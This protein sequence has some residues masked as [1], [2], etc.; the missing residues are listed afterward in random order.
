MEKSHGRSSLLFPGICLFLFLFLGTTFAAPD[1]P[2]N[3]LLI[4]ADDL[5]YGDVG[6]HGGRIPTPHIDSLARNGMAF[7]QG[8]VTAPQCAPSRAG[9]LTG[10]Y[11][12][13]FGFESNFEKPGR[14]GEPFPGAGLPMEERTMADYLRAAGYH[15]GVIGKWHL[16]GEPQFHP[17]Q[18]GFDEFFGF[19][20]GLSHYL[21]PT[22][23]AI[24]GEWDWD[25][26]AEVSASSMGSA[27]RPIPRMIRNNN[28][29]KVT[30]YLTDVLGEEASAFIERNKDKPWFL[31]LAFNAPHVPLEAS[32]KYL[33]RF[34]DI[35]DPSAR[36]YAAM[37]SAL[38]DAVGGTMQTLKNLH[39]D[40]R[41]IVVFLSDNGAPLREVPSASNAP[42]RGEKGNVL[43][44]GVRVPFFAQ[45]EGHIPA[46]TK[47]HATVSTLDLLPTFLALAGSPSPPDVEL[48][49]KNLLNTLTSG[50]E[51]ADQR[52]LCWQFRLSQSSPDSIPMWGIRQG[53]WKLLHGPGMALNGSTNTAL[54]D[55][56]NDI[57]ENH[58]LSGENPEKRKELEAELRKWMRTLQ[59][60]RWG[61]SKGKAS[62][63]IPEE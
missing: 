51:P 45:W 3:I 39:L 4:L 59:S 11:Q 53:S 37:I 52:I 46:G 9:L 36:T 23:Q 62:P 48:D 7:E 31:Y 33:E 34:P 8:Y 35:A 20:G 54:F 61:D 56:G 19:L 14:S 2:P 47:I 17:L 1:R 16:G 30:S 60:P 57:H 21:G 58:D 38:D 15:T 12:Q 22:K 28:P 5:G 44:G 42:L 43:E 24:P 18:R 32:P 41:T 10:R 29:V 26:L 50:K 49:G 55:L 63:P 40:E 25:P 13:K 6:F 27:E